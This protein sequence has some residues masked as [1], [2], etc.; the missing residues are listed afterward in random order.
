MKNLLSR[1]LNAAHRFTGFNFVIFK[2]CL[3]SIGILLGTYFANFFRSWILILWIIAVI[4]IISMWII[5]FRN[6]KSPKN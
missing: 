4:T 1:M 2:I 5:T 3:L 6:M